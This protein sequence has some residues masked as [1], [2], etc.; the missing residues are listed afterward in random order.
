MQGNNSMASVVIGAAIIGSSI[1]GG[2][3]M[4][5]SSVNRIESAVT[6]NGEQMETSL[7]ETKKALE[8]VASAKG[9]AAGTT[10]SRPRSAKEI[11]HQDRRSAGQRQRQRQGADC[12]VFRLSM[13]V[14]LE[15]RS[16]PQTDRRNLRQ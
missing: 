3:W 15:G 13:T 10:A 16:D 1:L 7:A 2:S 9:A 8:R 11:R 14:L 6:E 4:V 12:R 5:K